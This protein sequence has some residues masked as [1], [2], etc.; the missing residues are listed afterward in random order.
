[1]SSPFILK[2]RSRHSSFYL[3]YSIQ[4]PFTKLHNSNLYCYLS[5]DFADLSNYYFLIS[6]VVALSVDSLLDAITIFAV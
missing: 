6:V 3:F 2:C 4:T 5:M 1:M